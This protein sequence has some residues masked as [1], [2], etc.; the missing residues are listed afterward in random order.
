MTG[1]QMK[2]MSV[3]E[4]AKLIG[5]NEKTVYRMIREE[6]IVAV[7]E[8]GKLRVNVDKNLLKVIDRAQQALDEAKAILLNIEKASEQLVKPAKGVI[9]TA[10]PAAKKNLVTKSTKTAVKPVKKA[11]KKAVK[12]LKKSTKTVTNK[13]KK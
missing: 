3:K 13:K 7:K 6:S 11:V 8:K 2:Q 9:K 5:K 12:P 4:Y 10:Q 1:K